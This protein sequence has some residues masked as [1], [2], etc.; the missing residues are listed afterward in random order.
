MLT[1]WGKLQTSKWLPWYE[2]MRDWR[3]L[4]FLVYASLGSCNSPMLESWGVGV[5]MISWK[6]Q[7]PGL[8][9]L[10]VWPTYRTLGSQFLNTTKKLVRLSLWNHPLSH[11]ITW[12]PPTPGKCCLQIHNHLTHILSWNHISFL[13][14][15]WKI[16]SN[17]SVWMHFFIHVIHM[18]LKRF[19]F[20]LFCIF[21]SLHSFLEN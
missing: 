17:F 5:C 19:N 11:P 4:D 21:L 1:I 13:H 8:V 3:S 12:H 15:F 10:T 18:F 6:L 20:S 7:L 16:S 2:S 14:F 9:T